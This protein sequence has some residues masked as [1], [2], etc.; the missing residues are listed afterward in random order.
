M[1]FV[2]LGFH[3]LLQSTG[4]QRLTTILARQIE[5]AGLLKVSLQT[6]TPTPVRL[7]IEGRLCCMVEVGHYMAHVKKKQELL[8]LNFLCELNENVIVQ[9]VRN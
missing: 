7:C 3:F 1:P 8:R 6:G 5:S 2:M 9:I 4:R